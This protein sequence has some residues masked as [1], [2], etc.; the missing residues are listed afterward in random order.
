MGSSDNNPNNF[1]GGNHEDPFNLQIVSRN[2]GGGG[3]GMNQVAGVNVANM[4][5]V[6]HQNDNSDQ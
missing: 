6:K 1:T 4:S 5:L 3:N 2:N